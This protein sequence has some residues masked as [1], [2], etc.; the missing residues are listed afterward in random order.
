[1]LPD[2]APLAICGTLLQQLSFLQ[3][4]PGSPAPRLRLSYGMSLLVMV[5]Q[6]NNTRHCTLAQSY[7]PFLIVRGSFLGSRRFRRGIILDE[8]A[9]YLHDIGLQC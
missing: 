6:S 8:V 3:I 4:S 9:K 2:F 1:M 7:F 5:S